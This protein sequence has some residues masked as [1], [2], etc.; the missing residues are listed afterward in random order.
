[1]NLNQTEIL[2]LPILLLVP[3]F[4]PATHPPV[5]DLHPSHLELLPLMKFRQLLSLTISPNLREIINRLYDTLSTALQDL[6]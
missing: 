6:W 4:L 2:L 1:M 5:R 3:Q